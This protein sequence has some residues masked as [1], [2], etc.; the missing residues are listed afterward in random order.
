MSVRKLSRM[1]FLVNTLQFT[2]GTVILF[3]L[4]GEVLVYREEILDLA[5]FLVIFSSLL[6]IAGL[7][8]LTRFQRRNY[9][10]SMENLENLNAKLREQ[11]HDYLNQVQ[12]VHGL[13][14]LEEYESAREY[15]RPVF[16]D[17]M[18]VNRALK[19]AQPAVN[20]LLQAKLETAER[21]GIDFYLEV[22]TQLKE[23]KIEAWELCKILANL[24]DNA[25][26]A[27][28]QKEGE[29]QIRLQMEE[30][31][32]D[33]M[34]RI[35]N[36]GP[37][38][39]AAQQKLIFGRGYTTKKGEGHGIGLAIVSSILKEADGSIELQSNETET[40]FFVT[41]SRSV[42]GKISGRRQNRR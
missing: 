17:I 18:K 8:F 9:E 28:K 32:S 5:V 24:L 22:G 21:Q 33:Y 19:T 31:K 23:L 29:K 39:P 41:L 16:K 15:L 10:E 20:A 37:E 4:W 2:L 40:I 25:I 30:N 14:E 35:A 42:Q 27:V 36:N 38:I 11:R 12:V 13:L 34:F 3:A 6:S 1:L 7:F 26:T